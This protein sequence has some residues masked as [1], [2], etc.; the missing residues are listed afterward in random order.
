MASLLGVAEEEIAGNAPTGCDGN[1]S[2]S[3]QGGLSVAS[4]TDVEDS[5]MEDFETLKKWCCE[6]VRK[7]GGGNPRLM[8]FK[9]TAEDEPCKFHSGDTKDLEKYCLCFPGPSES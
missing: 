5:G 9:Q 1:A 6:A 7:K 2:S 8:L 4:A 3:W